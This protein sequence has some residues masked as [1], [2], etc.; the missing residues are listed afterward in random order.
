MR[1]QG[2]RDEKRGHTMATSIFLH[3]NDGRG[4]EVKLPK[5]KPWIRTASTMLSGLNWTRVQVRLFL[6]RGQVEEL[7]ST[8]NAFLI[9]N[10]L[11][12]NTGRT[13]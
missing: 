5:R 12:T 10:P 1:G 2:S 13:G 11:K 6:D 3:A 4:F 8:I 7:R 9:D